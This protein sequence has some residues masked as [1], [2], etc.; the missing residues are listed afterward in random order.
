[1]KLRLIQPGKP[2]QNEF[3]ES[4][5]ARFRDE[6]LNEPCFSEIRR[7][8]K[9]ITDWRQD[10]NVCR[11]HSSLDH[12]TPAEFAARWRNGECEGKQADITH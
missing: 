4:F 9:T 1:M 10:Y 5:N 2:M 3:I 7:T 8:R 12:Q 6:C 11:P